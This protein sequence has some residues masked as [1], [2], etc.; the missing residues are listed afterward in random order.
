MRLPADRHP[1]RRR[2][3]GAVALA[4]ALTLLAGGC[5]DQQEKYCDAV[6]D[7]QRE[8]GAE[9][10]DGAPDALLKALPTFKELESEAPED[11]KDEWTTVIDALEGLQHALEDADVD[12]ST[13]DRDH[14]PT[15]LSPDDKDAIDAAARQLTSDETVTAFSGVDQHAKDVCGTPLQVG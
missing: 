6:R 15:G 11:I 8:L 12:P 5:K 14:P 2:A 9:L 3:A 1:G 4:I 13:Y 7:H 10:G